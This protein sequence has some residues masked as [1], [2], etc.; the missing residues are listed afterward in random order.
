M[1][2]QLTLSRTLIAAPVWALT[3]LLA[4]TSPA[5]NAEATQVAAAQAQQAETAIW[6]D[7]RT[8]EE[9]NAGHL[10]GAVHIPHEQIADKIAA[11]TA[12][13]NAVIY[14]YCRSGR[15]SGLALESLQALGYSKVV[16]AGGY[17]ALKAKKTTGQ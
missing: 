14:L 16:N 7:V 5:S 9:Y 3:L 13:K 10:Q 17:E 2:T 6:I 12:D 11:V 4:I 15:R 8:A 1:N